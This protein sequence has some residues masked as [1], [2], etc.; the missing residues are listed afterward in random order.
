MNCPG[1]CGQHEIAPCRENIGLW[2]QRRRVSGASAVFDRMRPRPQ[3]NAAAKSKKRFVERAAGSLCL[4]RV[5]P[6]VRCAAKQIFYRPFTP[7][8]SFPRRPVPHVPFACGCRTVGGAFPFSYFPVKTMPPGAV[9]LFPHQGAVCLLPAFTG[10]VQTSCAAFL[11]RKN[12]SAP[13]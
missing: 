2:P 4:E 12:F 9:R 3:I 6:L 5:F 11:T 10:A 7:R 13:S 8:P 1:S